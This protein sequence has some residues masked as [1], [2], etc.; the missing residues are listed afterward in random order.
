LRSR[1]RAH[2]WKEEIDLVAEEMARVERYLTWEKDKW[3]AA[4]IK[5]QNDEE[6]ISGHVPV[7][8]NEGLAG[9]AYRQADLRDRMRCHFRYL[10]RYVDDWRKDPQL[11][12]TARNWYADSIRPDKSVYLYK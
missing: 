6:N 3:M 11:I 12:P 9:Y 5:R 7:A 2:R 1:A 10:W 8:L 4:A